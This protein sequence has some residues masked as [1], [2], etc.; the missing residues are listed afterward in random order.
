MKNR[1]YDAKMHGVNW[2]SGNGSPAHD[3]FAGYTG[4]VS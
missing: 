1:F 2:A 3:C 4:F